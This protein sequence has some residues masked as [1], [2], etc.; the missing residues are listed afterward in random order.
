M[1]RSAAEL[2]M[3]RRLLHRHWRR[4]VL[5]A[6]VAVGLAVGA[7]LLTQANEEANEASEIEANLARRGVTDEAERDLAA[8]LRDQEITADAAA[9]VVAALRATFGAADLSDLD[10]ALLLAAWEETDTTPHDSA[11]RTLSQIANGLG[12]SREAFASFVRTVTNEVST[13]QLPPRVT[14]A[15]FSEHAYEY[16]TACELVEGAPCPID[17]VI[18]LVS[19]RQQTEY[20]QWGHVDCLD[21]ANAAHPGC[22]TFADCSGEYALALA[23]QA[24]S[25]DDW[26]TARAL[27]HE[28]GSDGWEEW[29]AAGNEAVLAT[30]DA[31]E[32]C[33]TERYGEGVEAY[34]SLVFAR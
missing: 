6:I 21:A 1:R 27:G 30:W 31:H 8:A 9:N 10:A 25:N 12:V 4:L 29:T 33:V 2:R 14:L 7:R 22:L 28:P 19:D 26:E 24:A 16:N 20:E 5:L 32:A 15:G 17:V 23:A 18:T 3:V 11:S 34:K 13:R